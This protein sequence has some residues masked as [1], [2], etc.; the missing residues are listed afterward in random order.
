MAETEP[1]ANETLAVTEKEEQKMDVEVQAADDAADNGGSKRP[2]ED[3]ENGDDTKKPKLDECVKEEKK[4]GSDPVSIGSKSFVSSVEMFGY[5]YKLLHSWS[6]NLNLNKYEHMVLLGL[7]KKGH[8]EPERKIGTGVRAF[9]IRFHP[10]F[11][12]RCFFIVRDDDSVDDFSFRKCV[13]QIQPLPANMQSKHYAS[14]GKGGGGGGRGGYGRGR[15][16]GR[17]KPRY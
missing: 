2:R 8:S 13:D 12:S 14:G 5:F 11:K 17:G 10:H 9:Q 16:G 3:E 15:G 1:K 6:L 7:L 4:D